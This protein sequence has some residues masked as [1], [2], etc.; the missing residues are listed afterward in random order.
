MKKILTLIL[1]LCSTLFAVAERVNS[2]PFVVPELTSWQ[3]GEGNFLPSGRVVVKSK[4]LRAV[5]EKFAADYRTLFGRSLVL[6]S[7]Q[8]KEGDFVFALQAENE[9][10]PLGKE[11]Y[12]LSVGTTASVSAVTEQGAFWATRTILQISEQTASRT[13]PRGTAV[14]LPAYPLRGFMIDCGRKYIPMS[15]LRQLV[16]VMAYY[17]MNCLQVHLNDNGFK[18]YFGNDWSKTQAAFRLESDFFP[19]L[20]AKDGSYTKK[21]FIDFQIEAEKQFVEIIPE[22]DVPAHSLAFSHYRPSLGSEE[23]GLDHLDLNNPHL[24]PFLDSLF[25]EYCQGPRPVFRGK[26]VHIGTD[27][28]SNKDKAIVEKFRALTDHLIRHVEKHGKQAVAWGALTHAKGDTPVK[29]DNVVMQI[30]YNGYADPVK[31]KELGY[32]LIS[33]PDGYVYIVPAAGY[34]Y[35]YLNCRWLY[36]GWTPAQIGKVKFEDGDPSLLGGMF[37]VW[38]DHVG[39]GITVKDIHHR[40]MPALQTLSVK[41]WTATKTSLPYEEFSHRAL[42]L[43]EAPGVDE[44]ARTLGRN[45]RTAVEYPA[46]ELLPNSTLDWFGKEIGYDYSVSFDLHAEEVNPGNVL[47]TSPNAT[48]YL[49]SPNGGK[50]AFEREG[51]LNEF[52]YVVPK[53]KKVRLTIQGTNKETRLLVD[54]RFRQALYPLTIGGVSANAGAAGATADPYSAAKMYYQRTLVFPLQKTGNFKGK[55]SRLSVSNYIP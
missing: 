11:G 1:F 15:Y 41:C 46:L 19:G 21:E 44:L 51:Y 24:V 28:Y 7:G 39:N 16:S 43:S 34:Y 4:Q 25:T 12:K 14:D 27:E 6:T 37:A 10:E 33:I 22:I 42:Y 29:S 26:R 36:E 35:D 2:K 13:L 38:N 9:K 3:G 40:V 47:F 5:A 17:K 23:Y 50:L 30:W 55:I 53:G 31:M 49:A 48:V 20:T 18:Q 32:Q 54:G 8:P 45:T 52:D